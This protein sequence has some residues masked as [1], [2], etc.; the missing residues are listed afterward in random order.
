ME[1]EQWNLLYALAGQL[2]KQVNDRG[3]FTTAFIVA[4]FLWSVIHDRPVAWA[5]RARS[6]P[7]DLRPSHLPSQS[8]MSRRLRAPA[9][10]LLLEAMAATFR[11]P[12][13]QNDVQ[14]ID[15]KP[16]PVG[17]YTKDSDARWGRA[18]GGHWK[19]YK[20][21][22]IWGRGPMPIAWKVAAMSTSEKRVARELIPQLRGTGH[23]LG[24]N[25]Y[26]ASRLYDLAARQ[27]YQLLAPRQRSGGLGHHYQSPHRIFAI[28]FLQTPAGQKLF[29][30]R[31][32]IE[33]CFGNWT[34]FGGGLAPLPSWVRRPHRVTAWIHAKLLINAA[35]IEKK[36]PAS[37]TAVA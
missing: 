11:Q 18:A 17:G 34:S 8:T 30:Q 13:Q 6:W 24:D 12:A 21:F 36:A 19:G 35:R 31:V 4:V 14:I 27:R 16:L 33:R 37:T 9:T 28:G 15:A 20:F 3:R 7:D 25:Q 26:D 5:C 22:A 2:G 32:A 23:L 10:T 29:Q 1:R